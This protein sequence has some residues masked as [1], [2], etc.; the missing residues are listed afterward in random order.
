V[1]NVSILRRLERIE[2]TFEARAEVLRLEDGRNVIL[3][4]GAMIDVS[5]AFSNLIY[6]GELSWRDRLIP[7]EWIEAYARSLPQPG[8]GTITQA[9]RELCR[10][11]LSG[12]DLTT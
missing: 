9:F 1:G 4:P 6:E 11:Y 7:H 3:P 12:E 2:G 10:R 5:L 8:E